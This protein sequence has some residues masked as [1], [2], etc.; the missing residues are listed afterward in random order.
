M[1]DSK[2]N[3]NTKYQNNKN[4]F[5]NRYQ[6]SKNRFSAVSTFACLCSSVFFIFVCEA[7]S[8]IEKEG[9]DGKEGRKE[10]E[11]IKKG[12][13]GNKRKAPKEEKEIT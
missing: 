2:N 1:S 8:C 13:A 6:N 7:S 9:A 10:G 5:S 3:F 12:N 11:N 4:D